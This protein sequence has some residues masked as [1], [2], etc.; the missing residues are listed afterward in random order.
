MLHVWFYYLFIYLPFLRGE[1]PNISLVLST[2]LIKTLTSV[3]KHLAVQV[4]LK[5]QHSA[6]LVAVHAYVNKKNST[7]L[8]IKATQ[9]EK[10]LRH[11]TMLQGRPVVAHG[12]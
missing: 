7:P 3:N 10:Y 6:S 1:K 2:K 8:K 11:A 9:L 5:M 12:P 4:F